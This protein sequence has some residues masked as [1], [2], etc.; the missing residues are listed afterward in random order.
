MN[1]TKPKT[2]W[3]GVFL[4][5]IIGFFISGAIFSVFFYRV[6]TEKT[7]TSVILDESTA[8]L[9]AVSNSDLEKL[10]TYIHPQK[11]LRFSPYSYVDLKR[12]IVLKRD[13]LTKAVWDKSFTWG[14]Y[15]GSGEPINLT[16]RAY[17]K[18]FLYDQD[19]LHTKT[20]GLN[21][22][23]GQ[24]NTKNNAFEVYPSAIIVEYYYPGTEM[25][26]GMN[27]KSLRLLFEKSGRDWY[28]VG[29]IH[30]QWTI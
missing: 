27:W 4:G 17:F 20:I 9:Q 13:Q 28:L 21:H 25:Y 15:D 30:D 16:T 10:S 14:N 6:N 22:I 2:T 23:I 19:F 5:L 26:S 7:L 12:N 24:G 8:V 1:K 29:I 11:G 18:K 3:R